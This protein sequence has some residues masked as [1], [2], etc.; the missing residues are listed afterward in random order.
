MNL[1]HLAEADTGSLELDLGV[2]PAGRSLLLSAS[3]LPPK[4]RMKGQELVQGKHSNTTCGHPDH[5]LSCTPRFSSA[6]NW[7]LI[8]VYIYQVQYDI[9][10]YVDNAEGSGQGINIYVISD[11]YH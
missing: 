1:A 11:R 8:I 4:D 6:F 10:I 9:S 3:L 5:P 2:P 7:Y